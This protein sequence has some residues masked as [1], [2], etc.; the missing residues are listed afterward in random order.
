MGIIVGR[1]DEAKVRARAEEM[2]VTPLGK[3]RLCGDPKG[4][5]VPGRGEVLSQEHLLWG[6]L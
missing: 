4:N 1:L 5:M 3:V 6:R 2:E